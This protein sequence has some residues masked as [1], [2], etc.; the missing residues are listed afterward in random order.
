MTSPESDTASLAATTKAVLYL[1]ST[2]P[3]RRAV[4][5]KLGVAFEVRTPHVDESPLAGESAQQLVARLAKAKAVAVAEDLEEGLVIGSDQVAVIDGDILG[6][7]GTH[8]RAVDQLRRASGKRVQFY[9]GLCLY[10]AATGAAQVEVVPFGVEFRPLSDKQIESYLQREQPY[11]AAGSFKS[12]G[13]GI[14]L[15]Q[16]LDGDDPNALVGLPLIVLVRMLA[17]EGVDVLTDY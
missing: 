5:S 7:P 14:A 16:R 13:L 15:F 12:E 4:L 10:N 1:A 8:A 6:K 9:T 3:F 11:N 2:S 17:H